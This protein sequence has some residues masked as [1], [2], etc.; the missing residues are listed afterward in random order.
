MT[1]RLKAGKFYLQNEY[2]LRF[3][4]HLIHEALL[5][6]TSLL[7]NLNNKKIFYI[8]LKESSQKYGIFLGMYKEDFF[9]EH[10][11]A[12]QNF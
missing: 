6:F 4:F 5:L 11:V 8:Q 3:P 7:N 2:T 10:V 9:S 1:E 12:F